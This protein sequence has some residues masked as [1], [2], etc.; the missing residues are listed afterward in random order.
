MMKS[1]KVTL[2]SL[3]KKFRNHQE[4]LRLIDL[5]V[6]KMQEDVE[7]DLLEGNMEHFIDH[8]Q[9]KIQGLIQFRIALEGE[10]TKEEDD[11]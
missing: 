11:I 7:V 9:K 4:L 1:E 2:G 8:Q 10:E 3:L 6:R 5:Y